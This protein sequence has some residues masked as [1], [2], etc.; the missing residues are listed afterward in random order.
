[1]STENELFNI[2]DRFSGFVDTPP[3]NFSST[4]DF[5]KGVITT[6]PEGSVK[7]YYAWEPPAVVEGQQ[8]I[9]ML[10]FTDAS[11]ALFNEKLDDTLS[12]RNGIE[13]VL[14][15]VG[16][17]SNGVD[18]RVVDESTF[19]QPTSTPTAQMDYEMKISILGIADKYTDEYTIVPITL[20]DT[21][22]P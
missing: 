6:T 3:S 9:L 2:L 19:P 10:K 7:I 14:E 22:T 18:L 16:L 17:T 20:D 4:S 15:K 5:S 1:V 12:I 13:T 11:G 8:S 21:Q